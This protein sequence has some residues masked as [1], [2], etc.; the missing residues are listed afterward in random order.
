MIEP[1][2]NLAELMTLAGQPAY[3]YRFAYVAQALREKTPGATHGSEIPFAF[4]GVTALMQEKASDADVAMGKMMSGYWVSFVKTG[5]PNGGGRPAWSRYDPASRDVLTFTDK[6]V[7][8]IPDPLK[9][10]LDLWRAVWER[11][12]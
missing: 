8:V 10:R 4:D 12:R 7:A 9:E 11:G 1:A 6:G 2:R 5:D 3:F